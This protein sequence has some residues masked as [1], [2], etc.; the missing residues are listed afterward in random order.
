MARTKNEI[1]V[2]KA[3]TGFGRELIASLKEAAAHKRGEIALP[4]RIVEPMSPARVREI[5]K[6]VARN[7][8]D[9]SRRFGVPART[10]EGWEQGKKVDIAARVLLTVIEKEPEAVERALSDAAAA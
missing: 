9:F 3:D 8:K 7:T 1:G 4:V 10:I 6:Q 2:A 5:R